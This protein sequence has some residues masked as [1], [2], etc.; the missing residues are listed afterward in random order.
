M[1]SRSGALLAL[2]LVLACAP[3]ARS[4]VPDFDPDAVPDAYVGAGAALAHPG[5]ARAWW[6]TPEGSLWN[7]DW[8]VAI[9]PSSGGDVAGPPRRIAAEDRWLPVLHWKRTSGAIEWRFELADG[10]SPSRDT[11]RVASLRVRAHNGGAAPAPARLRMTLRNPPSTP[12]FVVFDAVDPPPAWR[13]GHRGDDAIVHGWSDG[14]PATAGVLERD[15]TLAPGAATEWRVALPTHPERASDLAAWC[16]VAHARR[17]ADARRDWTERIERGASFE[18][19]DPETEN[20]LRGALVVLHACRERR[21]SGEVPIGSP[22]HY[23]DVWLRDGA[24]VIEALAVTGNIDVARALATGLLGL[25]LGHGPFLS[26]RGQ[27]DGT[28]Q[29]LWALGQAFLRPA[30]PART[31]STLARVAAAAEKAWRWA[32]WQRG[33]GREY[34]WPLATMLPW[35]EPR[36]NELV[37]AQLV[38]NDAWMIAGYRAAEALLRAAGREADAVKVAA[39]R[40]AYEADFGTALD[41]ST[42]VDVPPSWQGVG[43]D[44]GNLAVAHPCRV[45]PASHPRYRALSARVWSRHGGAGLLGYGGPDTLQYYYGADLAVGALLDGRR[46]A[47]DS[48]LEAMLRW[49]T[50]SGGAGELF[51]RG[52]A[53]GANLPPHGTSAAALVTLVRHALVEDGGDTLCLTLGAREIWWRGSRVR[54]APTRWGALDLAFS[55][56]PDEARWEWSP[57]PVPTKLTLPPGTR[58]AGAPPSPLVASPDPTVVVAPPGTR[59]ARVTLVPASVASR[60]L[61]GARG[62]ARRGRS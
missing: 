19:G 11:G 53:V 51:S 47:A 33:Y 44:W 61:P 60:T 56:S 34:G 5:A 8:Y 41:R 18:L 37:A 20:A 36:D 10:P 32:E 39:T 24:R 30:P 23:R 62:F 46:A 7:G 9:E 57:V 40:G 14:A 17:A 12:P 49:R 48:V 21:G 3:S 2:G 27:L 1:S 38:G 16:R 6:V 31:D 35:A 59:E 52:G 54:R 22:L 15:A 55:R 43:R 50:A 58:L 45:L 25:Q 4:P 13:W 29:A 26:Q 42:S 28:G